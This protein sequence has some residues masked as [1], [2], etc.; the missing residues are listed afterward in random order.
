M[1]DEAEKRAWIQKVLGID[2]GATGSGAPQQEWRPPQ[3]PLPIFMDA[4]EEVDVEIDR[5]QRKLR[6]YEDEDLDQIVEFGLFGA[7]QGETVGLIAALREAERG[8]EAARKRVIGAVQ[9]YQ[10]FLAGAPIV[11]LMEDNP[12]GVSVTRAD[13]R[14]ALSKL[15]RLASV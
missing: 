5:L 2:V 8:G 7:T 9:D 14:A 3:P 10:D 11:A 1:A 4:K 13:T 15:E 6:E 12:F